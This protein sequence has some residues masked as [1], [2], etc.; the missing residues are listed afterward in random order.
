MTDPNTIAAIACW[1]GA[2]LPAL[3]SHLAS[4]ENEEH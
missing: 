3:H 2:L 1:V 4:D